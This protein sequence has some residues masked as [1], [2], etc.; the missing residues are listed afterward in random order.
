MEWVWE[1]ALVHVA[2]GAVVS[3]REYKGGARVSSP[4]FSDAFPADDLLELLNLICSP[5]CPHPYD[6]TVAGTIA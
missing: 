2:S 5:R 4:Q 1:T 3:F 6:G